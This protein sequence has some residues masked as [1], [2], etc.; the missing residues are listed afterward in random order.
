MSP[1]ILAAILWLAPQVGQPQAQAYS[2]I[3]ERE[4]Q[5]WD[6]DPLLV[7]AVIQQESGW[8]PRA[9]SKT[10]DWGLLQVHVSRT[11]YSRYLDQPERLFN[12]ELNIRLGV[13][14]MALW[15][16]YHIGRCFGPHP[17]WAHFKYGRRIPRK[18]KGKKVDIIYRSLLAKFRG[19]V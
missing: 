13:R 10:Q 3:I 6:L 9:R 5:H 8:N 18:R 12:P 14:L 11:T 1:V 19:E 7:V 16:D 2:V 4:A 15:R 17:F